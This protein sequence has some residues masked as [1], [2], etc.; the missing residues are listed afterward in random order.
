M[1]ELHLIPK[2]DN[3]SLSI[4]RVELNLNI[5]QEINKHSKQYQVKNKNFTFHWVCLQYLGLGK[6]ESPPNTQ[7][8][9][10][11]HFPWKVKNNDPT[12]LT[13]NIPPPQRFN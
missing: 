5:T 13:T 11:F 7:Q 12:T 9:V 3:V 2:Q 8:M 10:L 1:K 6:K 4:L